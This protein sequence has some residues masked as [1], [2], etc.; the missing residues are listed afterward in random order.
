MYF[1][2]IC[3]VY[4][5]IVFCG[6][7]LSMAARYPWSNKNAPNTQWVSSE[8]YPD[9]FN[10]D[11]SSPAVHEE[12]IDVF[13]GNQI[14][15]GRFPMWNSFIACGTVVQEWFSTR[16]LFLYQ[17]LQDISPWQWRD[18][19]LLGRL[20]IAA[21]GVFLFLRLFGIS[22]YPSFCGGILFC[23]SGAM[24]IF[25]T[26]TE[27]SNVAMVLPYTLIGAE[28]LIRKQNIFSL[29]FCSLAAASLVLAGQPEV[30]FYGILFI[31][32][33]FFFRVFF[34][35][36][37]RKDVI[38][39]VSS[40]LLSM[41]LSLLVSLPF[42]IPFL[43]NS[44]QYHHL[45]YYGGTQGVETPTPLVNFIAIFLPGLLRWRSM[46]SSFTVNA[47]WD[48]LGGYTGIS[49]IFLILASFKKQWWG[50][51]SYLFFLCFG[52]FILLKNM[53]V[54][55]VSWIGRLPVFNQVWTPRWAG[56]IWNLSFSLSAALG[57]QALF[58]QQDE[59]KD[60]S[61]SDGRLIG[62]KVWLLVGLFILFLSLITGPLLWRIANWFLNLTESSIDLM[63]F[64]RFFFL[65]AAGII[66]YKSVK[67]LRISPLFFVL[68]FGVIL[69]I[70]NFPKQLLH[71]RIP[72]RDIFEI[73]DKLVIFSMWQSI[74]E[75]AALG[76]VMIL[77][78]FVALKQKLLNKS[79]IV[80]VISAV[81]VA[82]MTFH[83]TL[84]YEEVTRL[85]R[86][87]LYSTALLS[88]TLYMLFSKKKIES[89]KIKIGTSLFFIGIISVGLIGAK[90]IP[91]RGDAFRNLSPNF[92]Y[93]HNG[94]S[95]VLGIKGLLFPNISAALGIEDIK[96]IASVSLS[97]YQ[98]FQDYCLSIKPQ[99]KYKSLWFTGIMDP[100]T[101]Q[102]ISGH[103]RERFR[104]YSL[105]GVANY[106]SPDYE[107]IPYT[108]L[109]QDGVVK[110]YQN[111]AVMP[112]T[113]IVH[114]WHFSKNSQQ[115]LEWLLKNS[116]N[117]SS[118]AVVETG[119][120]IYEKSLSKNNL[121]KSKILSY[122]IH[123]VLISAESNAPGILVLTDTYHPSWRVL[124]D[125]VRADFFPA[126]LCFR[127]VFLEPGKHIVKFYYFPREFYISIGISLITLLGM[128][129]L[130]FRKFKI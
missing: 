87:F 22:F 123:S 29:A 36:K 49:G 127:G 76:L 41:V 10:V 111:L 12:P 50:R 19:F 77:T 25:L 21:M 104:F 130:I 126:D 28:L 102:D 94:Y 58:L 32:L 86:L 129:I 89:I 114:D 90:S 16:T 117:L 57:F 92:N 97:R 113:F 67:R 119:G 9:I 83:V 51:K 107:D 64:L 105:A 85:F 75:S 45:H 14:K 34:D 81:I 101:G 71:I 40:F 69:C 35:I 84:G 99:G 88:L 116:S 38:K 27:M 47:G 44:N 78:L 24:T 48:Y 106:F 6:K 17:L 61:I 80:P 63:M 39:K 59:K 42:F 124:V 108:K 62:A 52:V 73:K 31:V 96:S 65:G 98:L 115:S 15:Q 43:M 79:I 82:E 95:R 128:A 54:P 37:P 125:G 7:T 33:Y 13:V 18:F 30:A 46:V 55:I 2:L 4:L 26:F 66:L 8:K 3:V 112:R 68:L 1:L 100:E 60:D 118:S 121:S 53:G 70:L 56:P 23:F 93:T 122:N 110:N 11:I 20:F 91:K 120:L 103:I 109:V 5:P 72:F 74:V